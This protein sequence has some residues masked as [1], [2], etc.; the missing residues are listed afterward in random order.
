MI[1]AVP[2]LFVVNT[3][4]S[5]SQTTEKEWEALDKES[6]DLFKSGGHERAFVV[7]KRAV[8]FAEKTLKK[9]ILIL[10]LA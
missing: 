7:A 4:P 1:Y 5:Y 2:L 10:R 9:I 6:K 3:L 8:V